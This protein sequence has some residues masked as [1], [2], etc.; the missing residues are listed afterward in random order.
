VKKKKTK[1]QYVIRY[2]EKD[3]EL[4]GGYSF[5]QKKLKNG[6]VMLTPFPLQAKIFSSRAEALK[7]VIERN[8]QDYCIIR[9]LKD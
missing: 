5:L 1:Q 4:F 7:Q 2:K 8:E 3:F 9:K 6:I